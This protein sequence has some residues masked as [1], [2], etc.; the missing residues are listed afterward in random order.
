MLQLSLLTLRRLSLFIGLPPSGRR[1]NVIK[2]PPYFLFL[3]LTG[4]D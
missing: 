3:K 4:I 1:V 2:I